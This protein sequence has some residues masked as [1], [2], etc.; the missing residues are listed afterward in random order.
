MDIFLWFLVFDSLLSKD[1]IV[2]LNVG[3]GDAGLLKMGRV[4]ILVDAGP[5]RNRIIYELD[6]SLPFYR[7]KINLAIL[8]HPDL[9][10]IGGFFEVLKKYKIDFFISAS[11]LNNVFSFSPL[12]KKIVLRAR[13]KIIYKDNK[14]VFLWPPA[15]SEVFFGKNTND[16]ALVFQ[17][18]KK[19]ESKVIF[20]ADISSKIENELL[21]RYGE[22]LK[23]SI[24]KVAHHGSRKSTSDVFLAAVEPQIAVISVGPNSYGHPHREVLEKII[25]RKI[26]LLRTDKDGTIK[27]KI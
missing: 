25:K 19:D 9:D 12:T 3:Q 7:R 14:I 11:D 5:R 23:S 18:Y 26:R 1:E 10:H 13:D 8:T 22:K 17:F 20:T 16:S 4:S 6:K 2:F 15:K 27:L 21:A 24:L